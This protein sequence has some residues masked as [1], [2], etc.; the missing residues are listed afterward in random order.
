MLNNFLPSLKFR[1]RTWAGQ[2]P[3]AFFLLKNVFGADKENICTLDTELV[4]EGY[5]RSANSFAVWAFRLSQQREIKIAHHVH[6]PAQVIYAAKH[7]I[8][9]LILIREPADAVIALKIRYPWVS[10][11]DALYAY[12]LFYKR[13]QPYFE[14]FVLATFEEVTTDYGKVIRKVNEKFGT[15]FDVFEHSEENV[16][17]VF[18]RIEERARQLTGIEQVDGF[19]AFPSAKKEAIKKDL[20][21]ALDDPRLRSQLNQC[22]AIYAE[23]LQMRNKNVPDSE[24]VP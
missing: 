16:A 19:A 10:I 22:Q 18:A 8:P 1:I 20:R 4:I 21:T 23:M 11:R 13:I 14:S 17:K 12:R 6:V 3:T 7:G 5:P 24:A 2:Y 15:R 9:T